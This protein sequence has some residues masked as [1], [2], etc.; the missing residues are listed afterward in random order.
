MCEPCG[1]YVTPP[2]SRTSLTAV[3]CMV[4][5]RRKN[6]MLPRPAAAFL[7]FVPNRLLLV[8]R[9]KAPRRLSSL[10]GSLS[11]VQCSAVQRSAAH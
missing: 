9:L 8:F 5:R 2:A 3:N 7:T 6:T 11:V 4:S 1:T 10:H